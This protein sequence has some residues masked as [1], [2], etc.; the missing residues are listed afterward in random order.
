MSLY[1]IYFIYLLDCSFNSQLFTT[2][3]KTI[4]T[5]C[6]LSYVL[7]GMCFQE[8]YFNSDVSVTKIDS[9]NCYE[10]AKRWD[11]NDQCQFY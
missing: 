5:L 6:E 4:I 1:I 3:N 8:S 11:D 7:T 9:C 10:K 2:V